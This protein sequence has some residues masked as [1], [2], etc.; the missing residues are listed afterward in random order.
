MAVGYE[1]SSVLFR[2]LKWMPLLAFFWLFLVIGAGARAEGRI[3]V[4]LS[5]PAQAYRDVA[6]AFIASLGHKYPVQIAMLD[7][8]RDQDILQMD[9]AGELMVPVGV[10]AMQRLY[11]LRPARASVLSLMVPRAAVDQIIGAETDRESAV[12]IDQP[13]YRSLAFI[14]MLMPRVERVGV[15]LSG[16][17]QGKLAAYRQEALRLKVGLT[18]ETVSSSVDVP[19]ALQRLL[20][21]VDVF[22]MLPDSRVVNENTVR[23]ILLA[24]YRQ[25]IPV[26]GFSR[27]L[28]NAGAVAAVV[29]DPAAIGQEGAVLAKQWNPSTGA[30]PKARYASDFSLVFNH[31]VARS[32]G[33]LFPEDAQDLL[34]WRGSLE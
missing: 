23:Q 4:V 14:R 22:L 25:Q 6:D 3:D 20:H 24:C 5:E 19:Q 18:V 26:V 13:L 33:V 34:R 1:R 8:L 2:S 10:K 30:I 32:L 27:G 9:V 16:D 29:S 17:A 15:I 21:K 31:Q 11:D 28:T 7:D 12:Y